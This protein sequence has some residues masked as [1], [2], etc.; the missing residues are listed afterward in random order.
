MGD[1]GKISP[2]ESLPLPEGRHVKD[3]DA[4]QAFA[5]KAARAA[6]KVA[7]TVTPPKVEPVTAPPIPAPETQ[8]AKQSETLDS[9]ACGSLFLMAD[10]A[11]SECVDSAEPP[12]P[13]EGK[14]A[15]ISRAD[16]G[17]T[18]T[19]RGL[20]T[21]DVQATTLTAEQANALFP[22]ETYGAYT[23]ERLHN[24]NVEN[25]K[26]SKHL[27]SKFVAHQYDRVLPALNESIQR[28]KAGEEINGFSGDRQVGTYLDSLGYTADLVRQWNKRYRDRIAALKNALGLVDGTNAGKLTPEQRELRDALKE[29]GYKHPE[30]TR[31]A[32]AAEGNSL[33]ERFNSVM[34]Q[35]AKEISGTVTGKDV[36]GRINAVIETS[37]PAPATGATEASIATEPLSVTTVTHVGELP[38]TQVDSTADKLREALANEPDRDVARDLLTAHLRVYADQFANDRITIKD[39]SAKV[40]FAGRDH[41]IM[42]GD[43]LEKRERNAPAALCK[44][45]GIKEY[46]LRRTVSE[47]TDGGWKKEHVIFFDSESDYRVIR[48]EVARKLA[49][50][51]FPSERTTPTPS[52]GL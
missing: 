50:D 5:R 52:E 37:N 32:Q 27:H 30:A 33:I 51:A 21:S 11:A 26:E 15:P 10:A 13:E 47:W 40:E 22:T 31:L 25:F 36:S 45:T 12:K 8:T 44:C 24:T 34:A 3:F 23:A 14:V 1:F 43:F 2:I 16:L 41:R 9:N 35:R 20:F 18:D 19:T 46:M 29:Q 49:P 48:E 42:P 28:L 7:A 39:V 17:E 4:A 38:L 6:K